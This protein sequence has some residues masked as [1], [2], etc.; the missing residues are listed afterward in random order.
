MWRINGSFILMCIMSLVILGQIFRIQFVEG[1]KWKAKADSLTLQY[2][3]IEASRGNIFSADGSLLS[4][5]IPIYDVRMDT[6]TSGLTKELF[7]AN[8]DS[9]SI[10]LATLFNDRPASDYRSYL[11]QSYGRKDRYCLIRRNVRYTEL[12]QLKTFPLFRLG[13]YKGGLLVEQKDMREMPFKMLAART[14]G[15]MRDVK[16]VGVEASFNNELQGTGGKR[17]MQRLSGNHWMPVTDKDEIEPKN[18]KDLVTTIDINIQD[19][20]ETSLMK[21]LA[22]HNAD[23]GCAVLMEVQT[24]EIK[25]I[26]NLSRTSDGSYIENFNYVIGE[27]TEPG[28]TMKTASL[29]AALDEGLIEPDDTVNVGNGSYTFYRQRM[30]DSHAPFRSRMSV[31]ECYEHSSNVGVSKIVTQTF[32]KRPQVFVDKLKAFGLGDAL[33]LQIEGEGQPRIK[34]TNVK[35]WTPVSLPWMSIGY[36]L[37]LTPLQML[38]F[39]NAIANN[40]R[41]VKPK[42]VKEI[43]EHGHV[44]KS[45]PVEIIRDSIASPEAIRKIRSMMEGVVERGTASSLNKSP[46]KIAGKTGTAQIVN[47]FGYDKSHMTYQA[48]FAGYFPAD[49]PRYSCIVVVYAPANSDYYG[50][51]V[52]APIFKEIADK[53]YANHLELHEHPIEKDT[54]VNILPLAKAGTQK[55]LKKVLAGLNISFESEAEDAQY[56]SVQAEETGISLK[57]RKE[58]AGIV[59]NVIGMGAMDAIYLIENAG[60]RVLLNGRGRVVKQSITPGTKTVKGLVISLELGL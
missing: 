16:P 13:R 42:F 56:V 6:R 2:I 32:A 52:S 33:G 40:G 4:T 20:A 43:R 21:H 30:K 17:L 14:I 51:A 36:E 46:Y 44:V 48:S 41:V 59:P 23:H 60:M 53:V 19:V 15:Y 24:G 47:K 11:R 29:L 25:A 27:A 38:T 7:D 1:D 54:T 26:A 9:L 5:S 49:E 10:C 12:Q 37:K 55:H 31:Q 35:D 22:K 8:I 34:N 58:S 57:E 3:N 45:F 50:G 28:S 39:Y 18:G